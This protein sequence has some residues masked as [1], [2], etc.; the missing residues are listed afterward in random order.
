MEAALNCFISGTVVFVQPVP[1]K[2]AMVPLSLPYSPPPANAYMFLPCFAI[3][4]ILVCWLGKVSTV[5]HVPFA[6]FC[7]LVAPPLESA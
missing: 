2:T 5:L 6:Y 4:W 1:S 7:I 3:W